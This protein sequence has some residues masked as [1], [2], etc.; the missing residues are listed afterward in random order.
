MVEV[1]SSPPRDT[2]LVLAELSRI[3][4]AELPLTDALGR[5]AE[6]ACAA[7]PGT[8]AASVTL[9]EHGRVRSFGVTGPL[10]EALDERQYET[11]F[12]PCLEAA[13]S[14]TAVVIE[15]TAHE[16]VHP[17]F[18]VLARQLGVT[19]VLSVGLGLNSRVVG[20]LNVYRDDGS[21]DDVVVEL[22][23]EFARYAAVV[24][25][26]AAGYAGA[27]ALA[28]H[29]RM[30]LSSRAVIEQAKGVLMERHGWGPE[31]ASSFLTAEA[32]RHGR[33]LRDVA[34]ELVG[35]VQGR[36]APFVPGGMP[37]PGQRGGELT[38]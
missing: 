36:T 34:A 14:G 23:T 37:G 26:N 1:P 12:G 13:L 2:A 9:V 38:S 6:L 7:I 28:G 32:E 15:D 4:L 27:T 25:D 11:G 5:I 22:A 19:N 21:P 18:A 35:S 16:S 33:K 8:A 3:S 29:L 10:A 24:V 17:E 31:K 20:A 30:A